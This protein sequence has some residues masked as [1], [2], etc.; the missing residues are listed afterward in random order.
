M[1][2]EDNTLLCFEA[3]NFFSIPR[4]VEDFEPTEEMMSFWVRPSIARTQD[5]EISEIEELYGT[6]GDADSEVEEDLIHPIVVFEA[7]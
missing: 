3:F 1:D 2:I 4:D 7:M 5:V 6:E